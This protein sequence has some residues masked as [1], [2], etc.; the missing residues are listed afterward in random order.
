MIN[1]LFQN[2][3]KLKTIFIYFC[4]FLLLAMKLFAKGCV[5]KRKICQYLSFVTIN[6]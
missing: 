6:L 5:L 2:T 1:I 3:I 4:A